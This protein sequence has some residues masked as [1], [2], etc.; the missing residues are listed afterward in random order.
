VNAEATRAAPG[1][2][3]IAV[4][5]AAFIASVAV[6][7]RLDRETQPPL[8][9]VVYV[10]SGATL[11]RLSLG[12]NGF[13]ADLYW[14]RA[15]QYFGRQRLA[16][17]GDFQNLGQLLRITTELDPHLIIAYRFGAI[18]LAEKPPE[19]AGRPDEALDLIRRGISANPSYWRLWQDLGFIYYWDLK[20]YA[21]AARAFEDGSRRPGAGL[22]MKTLAASVA[23]QGGELETS[24]L[25]WSE[26]LSAADS[27]SVR[28]SAQD[29]LA[30][31]R[32]E[33]DIEQLNR[34]LAEFARREGRA[35]RSL[36]DLER[37]ALLPGW[38][39]DP[40]GV[41]YEISADGKAA[42]GPGSRVDL[43][44]AR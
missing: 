22:W 3:A 27:Q 5:I 38:P 42:L 41:R 32:A 17:A 40:S 15:V 31:I 23:A 11:R 10:N 35:A 24:R 34:L 30:A 33:E 9:P 14:T 6:R 29:H 43:R 21:Q 18:F 12:Y 1:R 7:T 16:G 25:L 13:L 4:L 26:V 28:S 36:D 20:D 44:L 2:A 39:V 37:S 8:S 19:G